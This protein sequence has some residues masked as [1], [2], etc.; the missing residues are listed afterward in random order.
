MV[1]GPSSCLISDLVAQAEAELQS[2]GV[3]EIDRAY[4]AVMLS[5]GPAIEEDHP[6]TEDESG[7]HPLFP[8]IKQKTDVSSYLSPR[9][10][11]RAE[12]CG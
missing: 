5:S 11:R 10:G 2:L 12:P 1:V 9:F 6:V 3:A 7:E 8:M 4:D